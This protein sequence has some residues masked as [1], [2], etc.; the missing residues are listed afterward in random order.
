MI[1]NTGDI[2]IIESKD[3]CRDYSGN[4]WSNNFLKLRHAWR[5]DDITNNGKITAH[6]MHGKRKTIHALDRPP[7][8]PYIVKVISAKK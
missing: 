1:I 7:C 8:F 6:D 3:F 2:I 5:V 4:V